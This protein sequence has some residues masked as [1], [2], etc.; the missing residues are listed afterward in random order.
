VRPL[1]AA[2]VFNRRLVLVLAAPVYAGVFA[3][4]V[5]IEKPGLGI[6]HFFYV[7]ICLVALATDELWGAAAG[8]LGV[9]LYV[10]G[11]AVTPN[12]PTADGLT[13]S[14]VIRLVT[15]MGIGALLGGY[16]S[17]NR[18]LLGEAGQRAFQDF[19][20]GIG[21]ARFFH[22]KLAERCAEGKPFTLVLA[23]VDELGEINN[24]HGHDAGNAALCR[25]AAAL[26]EI[27][28]PSDDVARIGGDEF[29]FVTHLQPEQ[30]RHV[31]SRLAKTLA[32]ENLE[33]SFGTTSYPADGT[34]AVELFRKADD[35]LFAAKLL[36]RNRRTVAA[37][38]RR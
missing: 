34:A 16:A 15:F 2:G 14:S 1:S 26:R 32:A 21:N 4:L 35:R 8:L 24:V 30:A 10:G 37:Y 20:T 7:P 36:S 12:V 27:A 3:A 33:L 38:A 25:V 18:K 6:G 29:A 31:C 17:R 5:I 9:A 23:D 22:E 11:I 13:W 19:L 28:W